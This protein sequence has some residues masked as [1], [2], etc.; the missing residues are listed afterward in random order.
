MA[1]LK[2]YIVEDSAVIRENLAAALE[3]LAP[4]KVVGTAENEAT[5]VQWLAQP[6]NDCDLAIIDLFLRS[7]SGLGVLSAARGEQVARK[8]VVLS[9]GATPDMRR[10][11]MELGADAVFD[12][13]ND[14]D[15]LVNYCTRL[16]EERQGFDGAAIDSNRF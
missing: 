8:L 4:L 1:A 7:G 12:K 11:C 5:A 10:K 9:N 16:V 6:G 13:S 15:A 2:T 14:S 3:E